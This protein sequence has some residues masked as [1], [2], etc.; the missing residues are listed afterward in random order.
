M[1]AG[2]S[3]LVV[4]SILAVLALVGNWGAG[5][6]TCVA[7]EFEE[8]YG[9]WVNPDYNTETIPAKTVL[10]PDGTS[11]SY[12]TEDSTVGRWPGKLAITDKWSDSEGNVWYKVSYTYKMGGDSATSYRLARVSNSG[13]TLEWVES[14]SEYPKELSSKHPS[15]MIYQRQQ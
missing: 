13:A 12:G 15:Y 5:E 8:L 10:N 9:T 6:T 14:R 7:E 2:N 4:T 3:I 1:K 11:L